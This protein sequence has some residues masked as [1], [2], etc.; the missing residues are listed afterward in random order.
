ME[1]KKLKLDNIANGAAA[2]LFDRELSKV[3]ENIHDSNTDGKVKRSITLTVS[4]MPDANKE[5]A[6]ITLHAASKLAPVR[7]AFA[8]AQFARR[9]G[10]LDAFTHNINQEELDL[11]G[12]KEAKPKI[13]GGEAGFDA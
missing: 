8:T 13:V 4:I 1:W 5:G 11:Q 3:M 7:Q 10:K 9:N 12:L 2:E 6:N